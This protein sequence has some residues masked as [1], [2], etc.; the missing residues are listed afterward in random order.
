MGE[1]FLALIAIVAFCWLVFLLITPFLALRHSR[2]LNEIQEQIHEINASLAENTVNERRYAELQKEVLAL[3]AELKALQQH[4]PQTPPVVAV[5]DLSKTEPVASGQTQPMGVPPA[6]QA[7]RAAPPPPPQVEPPR[8]IP[9]PPPLPHARTTAPASD[10]PLKPD[11]PSPPRAESTAATSAQAAKPHTLADLEETV[12]TSWLSRIGMGMVVIGVALFLGYTYQRF[13]PAGKIAIATAVSALCIVAGLLL[14]RR[15]RYALFGHVLIAGGWSLAYFTAYAM[16]HI[17]ATQIIQSDAAGFAVLLIVAVCMIGHSL[18]YRSEVLTAF[19][20]LLAYLALAISPISGST[21]IASFLLAASIVVLAAILRW[22]GIEC[23]A[24]AGVY[25]SHLLWLVPIIRSIGMIKGPFPEYTFSTVLSSLYWLL[26]AI[27]HFLRR[28]TRTPQNHFLQSALILNTTGYVV[29]TSLQSPYNR[30]FSF[31]LVLGIVHLAMSGL[32]SF[33]NR[34]S[35]FLNA[36]TL[37]AILMVIAIPYRYSGNHLL[38]Y[39]LILIQAFLILGYRLKELQFRRLAWFGSI[40][41]ILYAIAHDVIPRFSAEGRI[42]TH[43]GATM[44]IIGLAFVFNSLVLAAR[45]AQQIKTERESESVTLFLYA[46]WGLTLIAAWFLLG[47]HWLAIGWLGLALTYSLAG[48]FLEERNLLLQGQWTAMFAFL[49]FLM[50]NLHDTGTTFFG[51]SRRILTGSIAALFLY[52]YNEL[53]RRDLLSDSS[54][55][56]ER[57]INSGMAATVLVLLVWYGLAPA[58]VALGW[59]LAALILIEAGRSLNRLDFRQQGHLI[60]V[61]TFLRILFANLNT[62]PSA[63]VLSGRLVTVLPIAALFYFLY[64][65]TRGNREKSDPSERGLPMMYSLFGLISILAVL[66]FELPAVWVATVWAAISVALALSGRKW[67]LVE[68]QSQAVLVGLIALARCGLEN[69]RIEPEP[70]FNTR[71]WGTTAVIAV[72]LAGFAWIRGAHAKREP[73]G[74]HGSWKQLF[75][76]PD[77]VYFIS[78]A[79]LTAALIALEVSHGYWTA[80]WAIEGFVIFL[81]AV[82]VTDRWYRLLGLCVLLF[83]TARIALV[84]VWKLGTLQRIVAFLALGVILVFVSFLYTRYKDAWKRLL[85]GE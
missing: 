22:Y 1:S 78:A 56:T 24:I 80:A 6:P 17:S 85:L 44:L 79:A 43:G 54:A 34:R 61:M 10:P 20:Y 27:S 14:E 47:N 64:A 70:G 76:S 62:L 29:L 11:A 36:S 59:G 50:V 18:K 8:V 52:V 40:P 66:R 9:V 26:F 41:L 77:D 82:I 72:F 48:H 60:A 3:R 31:L 37:G 55:R 2:R 42:D 71:L 83:C 12:G 35:S 15:E 7:A 67:Q 19:A 84:D 46:G 53:S 4:P 73:L 69:L 51:M 74:M 28:P 65:D 81:I 68:F 57:W 38:L 49:L 33:W 32:A 75:D 5:A 45:Y 23:L 16:R 58:S 21:L 30:A 13:G 25:F 39:W 63:D